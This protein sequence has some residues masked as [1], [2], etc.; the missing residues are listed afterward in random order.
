MTQ[1]RINRRI[2]PASG[3]QRR[4][5]EAAL[6]KM[7]ITKQVRLWNEATQMKGTK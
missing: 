2:R 3:Y 5:Q 1:R 7:G 6:Q 4:R